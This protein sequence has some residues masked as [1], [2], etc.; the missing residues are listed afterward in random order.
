MNIISHFNSKAEFT[1]YLAIGL[2]TIYHFYVP[3]MAPYSPAFSCA[4]LQGKSLF[5]WEIPL[6][7][8]G[9]GTAGDDMGKEAHCGNFFPQEK[10]T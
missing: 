6:S 2:S 9:A 4:V 5:S 3:F 10:N 7:K 1:L 8:A